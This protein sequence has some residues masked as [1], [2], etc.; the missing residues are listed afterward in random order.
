MAIKT[1]KPKTPGRRH[2]QVVDYSGLSKVKPKK[3]LV[4]GKKKTAGRNTFGR[5]TVRH[6]GGGAKRR[7]RLVDFG[8]KFLGLS[9]KIETLEYDPNRTAFISLVLLS[10]GKRVYLLA[11][12]GIKVGDTIEVA[13]KAEIKIGNRIR[14][15][16]IPVGTQVC[17][18]ELHSGQ[19][20]KLAR[21]AGAYATVM[22]HEGTYTHLKLPSG[23]VRKVSSSGFATIGQVSNFE[24][25]LVSLG[26][27]GRSRLM[28]RRP[29]VRGKAMNPRDHPYGGGEGRTTR[30]TKRPKDKWGNITGGRKTRK[31][32]KWSNKLI[33]QRR[34]KKKK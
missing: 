12:S 31:K 8:E 26:Q 27:A 25:R 34:P 30:G 20:G 28:G 2:Y 22:A 17:N 5:I 29:T 33:L 4:Q 11:P 7:Y 24:H 19:K 21:S 15:E 32:R 23:E 16:N 3:S 6:R 9:G 13:E 14:L 10:N 1:S 18:I